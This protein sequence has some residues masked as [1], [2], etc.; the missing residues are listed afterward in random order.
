MENTVA[1]QTND[2]LLVL[3][4]MGRKVIVLQTTLFHSM[5]PFNDSIG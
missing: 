2:E 3:I 5:L 4:A 1:A